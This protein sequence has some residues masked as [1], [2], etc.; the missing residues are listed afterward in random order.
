M[1]FCVN[2]CEQVQKFAALVTGFG[3]EGLDY[4]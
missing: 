4:R 1:G 2:L 3:I